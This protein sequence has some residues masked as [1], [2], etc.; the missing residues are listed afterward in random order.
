MIETLYFKERL[1]FGSTSVYFDSLHVWLTKT[2]WIVIDTTNAEFK[3]YNF[4]CCLK[5][6]F[7]S[8]VVYTVTD[9]QTDRQTSD[10][11]EP[12][13]T[14]YLFTEKGYS[15]SAVCFVYTHETTSYSCNVR[16][17]PVI[18][19]SQHTH[20]KFSPWLW[21]RIWCFCCYQ[22]FLVNITLL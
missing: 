2:L 4:N 19:F 5:C 21:R 9:R 17:F 15:T 14:S 16:D 22:Q 13:A 6:V 10:I 8:H 12:C 1:C 3:I 11:R 20:N 7:L 18:R